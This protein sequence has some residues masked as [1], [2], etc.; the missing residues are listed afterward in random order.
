MLVALDAVVR[1]TL[2]VPLILTCQVPMM[3]LEPSRTFPVCTVTTLCPLA[4][5]K[6]PVAVSAVDEAFDPVLKAGSLT[7]AV[8]LVGMLMAMPS[9]SKALSP[10]RLMMVR[11]SVP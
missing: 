3:L 4:R 6:A 2:K 5:V 8:V 10:S 1:E 7:V 11:K 9:L